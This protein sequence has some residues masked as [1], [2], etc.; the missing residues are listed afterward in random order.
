MAE[1]KIDGAADR[2]QT[3]RGRYEPA[4]RC[5]GV[6]AQDGAEH[7][8]DR[9]AKRVRVL[10]GRRFQLAKADDFSANRRPALASCLSMI[11]GRARGHAFPKTA[12]H[13]S[14]SCFSDRIG[15]GLADQ[16]EGRA[17][18]A[19]GALENVRRCASVATMQQ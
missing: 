11:P 4:V 5:G 1:V 17:K 14:G 19:A 3:D 7:T 12:A 13:F 15:G 2:S 9:A 6:P 16:R 10:L 8:G 18:L